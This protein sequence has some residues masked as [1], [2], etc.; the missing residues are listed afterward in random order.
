MKENKRKTKGDLW[1]K[2]GRD[3]VVE[4]LCIKAVYLDFR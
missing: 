3:G 1:P 2:N 4:F